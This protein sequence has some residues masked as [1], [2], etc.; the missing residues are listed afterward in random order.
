MVKVILQNYV[1]GKVHSQLKQVSYFTYSAIFLSLFCNLFYL[2]YIPTNL[3][4]IGQVTI[5][6]KKSIT[7]PLH[8]G[9]PVK[10]RQ[11]SV[12]GQTNIMLLFYIY[13][14]RTL[15]AKK[16]FIWLVLAMGPFSETNCCHRRVL[17]FIDRCVFIPISNF[18]VYMTSVRQ[19]IQVSMWFIFYL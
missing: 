14:P 4:E 2:L 15:L 19:Y 12:H 11:E 5:F 1:L 6:F 18:C 10:V 7:R 3:F 9:Y 13:T 8:N 16:V 17:D